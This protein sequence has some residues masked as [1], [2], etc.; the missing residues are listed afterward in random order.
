MYAWS[1]EDDD[2]D[3]EEEKEEEEM[4]MM[5][6]TTMMM[7]VSVFQYGIPCSCIKACISTEK[8]QIAWFSVMNDIITIPAKHPSMFST[9]S[10]AKSLMVPN[11]TGPLFTKW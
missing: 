5:M 10:S 2:D 6:T 4:M 11:S 8:K 3:D 7:I 1:W 9:T